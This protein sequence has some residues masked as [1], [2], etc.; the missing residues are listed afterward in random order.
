LERSARIREE[1]GGL[2]SVVEEGGHRSVGSRDASGSSSAHWVTAPNSPTHSMRAPAWWEGHVLRNPKA[3]DGAGWSDLSGG[4]FTK[5]GND[6]RT[7]S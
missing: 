4:G 1:G 3:M 2:R 6:M 7:Y 5:R